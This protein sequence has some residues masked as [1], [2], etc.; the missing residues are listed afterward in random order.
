MTFR[1]SGAAS[2]ARS[3]ARSLPTGGGLLIV[4][5]L[6]PLL[7]PPSMARSDVPE[8]SAGIDPEFRRHYRWILLKFIPA[9]DLRPGWFP[10]GAG[11]W[12]AGRHAAAVHGPAGLGLTRARPTT[13]GAPSTGCASST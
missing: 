3:T 6:R 10:A 7:Y 13:S 1:T 5:Q 11:Q 12:P 4:R 2:P 8:P 9:Q